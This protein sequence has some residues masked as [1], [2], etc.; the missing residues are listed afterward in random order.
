MQ[1]GPNGGFNRQ[2]TEP[3]ESMLANPQSA[4][5]NPQL[6]RLAVGLGA[7]ALLSIATVWAVW[8]IAGG[9]EFRSF[10]QQ[11]H[12]GDTSALSTPLIAQSFQSRDANLHRVEIELVGAIPQ[13]LPQ[14]VRVRLLAG[15]GLQ[16]QSIY[17][18]PLS[19]AGVISSAGDSY[20]SVSFPSLGDSEGKTYT[21][22]LMTPGYPIN[23]FMQPGYSPID[24]LS[25]GRLYM[26]GGP[27]PGDMAISAYYSYSLSTLLSDI[28]DAV[29]GHLPLIVEWLLLMTLPGLALLVWLPNDLNMGQKVLAAPGVM[30]LAWPLL[31]L[32]S[33]LV[34]F[35]FSTGR[36]WVLLALSAFAL[37][38]R[39]TLTWRSPKTQSAIRL[40]PSFAGS[41]PSE[42]AITTADLVFWGSLALVLLLT[43][44]TRLLSLRGLQAGV[45]MDA[46]HHTIISELFVRDGGIPSNYEP[47][48]PLQSFTY[49]FGF[50]GL[51]AALSWLSGQKSPTDI[52]VLMPQVGQF[53]GSV[54]PISSLALFGWKVLG[55]RWAGLAAGA[56]AGLVS[57]LPAY[58]V[59]WSRFTQGQA[60]ALLPVSWVL[61]L[62]NA[63]CGMRNAEYSE[64]N[65][66]TSFR[67]PHSTFHIPLAVIG[68]AGLFLTHY[69]IAI[70]YAGFVALYL[71]W[72]FV[73]AM[74]HGE[75]TAR[76][77]V[78]LSEAARVAIVGV[79]SLAVLLPW[80]LNL[81][82]NFVKNFIDTDV[83][84]ID[85]YFATAERLSVNILNH[86]SL[87]ILAIL[88][89]IAL[90]MLGWK[91]TDHPRMGLAIG[92]GAG[93]VGMAVTFYFYFNSTSVQMEKDL[94]VLVVGLSPVT[95]LLLVEIAAVG[96]LLWLAKRS[97]AMLLLPALVWL[98]LGLWSSPQLLPFRLPFVGYVDSVTLASG[99]WLPAVLLSGYAVV[100]MAMW[101]WERR[102]KY[103]V[104][105]TKYEVPSTKYQVPS[106]KWAKAYLVLGTSY[107]V[108][109]GLAS[110]LSLAPVHDRELYITQSDTEALLW[111]RDNLPGN[112][113]VLAN[114]FSFPWSPEQVLAVDSGLWIPYLAGVR[115]SV[116]TIAAYNEQPEDPDFFDKVLALVPS[117]PLSSDP[118][119]WKALKA[120]G[121]THVYIGS[122]AGDTGFSAQQ[123]LLNKN[124]TLVYHK[125]AVWLFKIT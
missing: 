21:L 81:A 31:L 77:K 47:Y 55:N 68:A 66:R 20:L 105:S 112:S 59:E 14:D 101:V 56:L 3:G 52:M 98:V 33:S 87:P 18:A 19:A 24:A 50:H 102:T 53:A 48:A 80:L 88:S 97:G 114:S 90:A 22:E 111:M 17:E 65:Q 73:Q 58:Y 83:T 108:L 60:L 91:E 36:M 115:S 70:L 13:S 124:V 72:T 64:S 32:F 110:G 35:T 117:A 25:S 123:L 67:I 7:L 76:F 5:R 30:A 118:A 61:L 27:Q 120:A 122:R 26:S 78:P 82:N 12:S 41:G 63:E 16:G 79:C 113:Y 10:Q 39:A 45:G 89:A 84:G 44:I 28:G 85:V 74:R 121:I 11:L 37:G 2:V 94:Q 46:Y 40:R 4:I 125:D 119:Q 95:W 29:S 75:G 57:V 6:N 34:E 42:S 1:I 100:N 49:H 96:A 103:Q 93:L 107:L 71:A 104:P 38:I 86:P 51:I 54:L 109:V 43:T 99:A 62:G 92:S 15:D 9:I 8:Q 69:R 116:Q 23:S 106:T